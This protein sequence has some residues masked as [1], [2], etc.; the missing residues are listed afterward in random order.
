[1]HSSSIP[2]SLDSKWKLTGQNP[3]GYLCPRKPVTNLIFRTSSAYMPSN[4]ARFEA[5]ASGEHADQ[6][7]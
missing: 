1:M 2:S 4:P 5:Y 6:I 3:C 7:F